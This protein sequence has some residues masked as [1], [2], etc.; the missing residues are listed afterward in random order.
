MAI[1]WLIDCCTGLISR[2]VVSRAIVLRVILITD[3]CK[4]S[5]APGSHIDCEEGVKLE[6]AVIVS[7]D[8]V[9]WD[10]QYVSRTS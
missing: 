1:K 10:E 7:K 4:I 5:A 8:N 3:C 9:A 2:L 6:Q